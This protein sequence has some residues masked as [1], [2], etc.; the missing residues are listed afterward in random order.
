MTDSA[1]I[2]TRKWLESFVIGYEICPFARKVFND[3]SIRYAVD[4]RTDAESCLQRLVD[5]CQRLDANEDIETTLLI[6]PCNFCNFDDYL[7][8]LELAMEL[9]KVQGY[10][11]I[12][13]LASFHPEYCFDGADEDDADN[14]TN[15][16]PFPML[17]LIREASIDAAL[18][19]HPDPEYIPDRNIELTRSLG[20]SKLKQILATA[21]KTT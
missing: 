2:Q 6:Y 21:R 18:K 10:E 13:Q 9:L 16:S 20:V 14:Y 7:D 17:H 15:R 8:Y 11:G 1:V 3:D 19:S 4:E 12:Y 5:E